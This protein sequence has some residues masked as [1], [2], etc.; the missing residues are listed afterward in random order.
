[1]LLSPCK[2]CSDRSPTCHTSCAAYQEY[3][4]EREN[5]LDHKRKIS[6]QADDYWSIRKHHMKGW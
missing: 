3:R 4:R 2:D 6:K 5:Y 1:M